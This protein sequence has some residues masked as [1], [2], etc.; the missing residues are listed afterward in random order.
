MERSTNSRVGHAITFL[1]VQ[2]MKNKEIELTIFIV[3]PI[4]K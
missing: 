2:S 1:L 4:A 3:T